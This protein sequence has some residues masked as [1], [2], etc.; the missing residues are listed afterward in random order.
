MDGSAIGC[1]RVKNCIE[2]ST[3]QVRTNFNE[4]L[5]VKLHLKIVY[6]NQMD[7]SQRGLEGCFT[8]FSYGSL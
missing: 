2:Q 7:C 6:I 8:S 4:K 3:W 5:D 1:K